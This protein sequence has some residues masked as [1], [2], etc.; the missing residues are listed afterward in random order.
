MVFTTLA[1]QCAVAIENAQLLDTLEEYNRNLEQKVT[2]RTRELAKK[3]SLIEKQI[4]RLQELDREKM[5]FFRFVTHEV[6]SPVNTVQSAIETTLMLSKEQL[7]ERCVGMLN[8]AL[9]RTGQVI[10]TV[11]DLSEMTRGG[12]PATPQL[13]TVNL[14]ELL[15]R[16]VDDEVADNPKKLRVDVVLPKQSIVIQSYPGMLEKIFANLIS[17]AVRY[18]SDGGELQI[19]LESSPNHY[20]VQVKDS[21]IGMSPEDQDKIFQEFYRSAAARQHA[22][23]GTRLGMS[24]VAKFVEQ[25]GGEIKVDSTPGKGST[26]RVALP[27]SIPDSG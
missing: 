16:I 18:N 23:I 26:F 6:K 7:D 24:I 21:G 12:L 20:L 14:N 5:D 22:K 4:T 15:T 9:D 11:K 8:R 27:E 10:E 25:L 17:N 19:K 1:A 13:Q 3:N 2:D